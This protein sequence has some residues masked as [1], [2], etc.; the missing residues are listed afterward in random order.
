MQVSPRSFAQLKAVFGDC[1]PKQNAAAMLDS[2]PVAPSNP[3]ELQALRT[4][5]VELA[6]K[7]LAEIAPAQTTSTTARPLPSAAVLQLG[8]LQAARELRSS[9]GLLRV[10]TEKRATAL[11]DTIAAMKDV[12]H[13]FLEEG[14]LHRSHVVAKRLEEAGIFCEKIFTIPTSGDLVMETAKA[15]LGFSVAIYHEAVVVHVARDDGSGIERRVLDPSVGDTPLTVEAWLST[16][17]PSPVTPMGEPIP[18]EE[19]GGLE[20]FFLPRFAYGLSDRNDPPAA[21][22]AEDLASA[23]KWND[24]WKVVQKDYEDGDFYDELKRLAGRA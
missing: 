19:R 24:E 1:L 14:C 6:G 3:A 13:T 7:K 21:W 16:M 20:T 4:L 12:P 5:V 22:R 10:L 2:S 15:K 8:Q 23:F 18:P 11:F 9:D 17:H